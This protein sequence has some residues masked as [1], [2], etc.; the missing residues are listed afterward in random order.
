MYSLF[1]SLLIQ[2]AIEQRIFNDISNAHLA[3]MI[4][5]NQL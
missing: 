3:Q 1:T 2:I 4:N 5:F